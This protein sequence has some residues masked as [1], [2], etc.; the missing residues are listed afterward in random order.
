MRCVLLNR[1]KTGF[2]DDNSKAGNS[3]ESTLFSQTTWINI[4][5]PCFRFLAVYS[6]RRSLRLWTSADRYPFPFKTVQSNM[7]SAPSFS[8]SRRV[9]AVSN[10]ISFASSS[11]KGVS[12]YKTP[13]NVTLTMSAGTKLSVEWCGTG[14]ERWK[15]GLGLLLWSACLDDAL[16]SL[17]TDRQVDWEWWPGQ[18]DKGEWG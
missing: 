16:I 5:Q 4:L 8:S 15:L 11:T 2:P 3:R 7:L 14:N 10:F 9:P 17:Q 12:V 1:N 6:P 18:Q 13:A